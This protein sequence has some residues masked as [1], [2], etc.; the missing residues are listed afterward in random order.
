[1][2]EL[3]KATSLR[4]FTGETERGGGRPLFEHIVLKAREAHLAGAT[5]LRGPLGYGHS[6]VLHTNKILRLSFDLPVVIEIIDTDEKVRQFLPQ[7]AQFDNCVVTLT[8]VWAAFED[9]R[10][11]STTP[12]AP[13]GQSPSAAPQRGGK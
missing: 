4:I 13:A 1:M 9:E 3:R 7:L 10:N 6:G 12:A 8:E 5:V 2:Q 11:A